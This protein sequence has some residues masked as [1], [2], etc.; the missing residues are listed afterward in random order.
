MRLAVRWVLALAL[1][2]ALG[3]ISAPA[4]ALADGRQVV[5]FSAS[6]SAPTPT[7]D[8][9]FDCTGVRTVDGTSVQDRETCVI[10]G[11]TGDFVPGTYVGH[12]AV[13]VPPFGLSAW[14]SDFDGSVADH[15]INRIVANG[16]GTL[17]Q[18][19]IAFYS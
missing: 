18:F 11:A 6:Y 19:T 13:F 10:S 14:A 3:A 17:T 9:V 7:G 8:A 1:A 4:I 5:P 12:P 15:Y 16:D 2:I